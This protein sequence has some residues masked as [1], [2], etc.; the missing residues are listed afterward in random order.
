MADPRHIFGRQAEQVAARHLKKR[1]Y[2]ILERNVY[3]R[4][5]ELDLVA[6][7]EDTLV[8]CEVRARKG[9]VGVE[10][11]ESIHAGKQR[12]LVQLASQYL[13]QHPELAQS[14]CRFDA[15]LVW[16]KGLFWQVEVVPDAFR[17]GW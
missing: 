4:S 5:G 2:Q 10:A 12:R 15:V 1:G 16:K 3:T 11:G 7:D 6:K 8:F 13:Q 14:A 9:A 17:P